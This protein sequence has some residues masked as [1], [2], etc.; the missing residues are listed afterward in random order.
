MNRGVAASDVTSIWALEKEIEAV[1][2]PGMPVKLKVRPTSC[3]LASMNRLTDPN[4][5]T[6]RR[7]ALLANSLSGPPGLPL[8]TSA[9]K[10]TRPASRA[11]A[12]PGQLHRQHV[13]VARRV[14]DDERGVGRHG[15][16]PEPAPTTDE[17]AERPP[18]RPPSRAVGEQDDLAGGLLQDELE[19]APSPGNEFDR[20]ASG[21][22]YEEIACSRRSETAATGPA[23]P[24]REPAP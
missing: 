10:A 2:L 11:Y 21:R 5:P 22:Q 8:S 6:T 9:R 17:A 3:P 13:A 20:S 19:H 24:H 15:S 18:P 14:G 4:R 1:L 16:V 23:R 7:S 12:R